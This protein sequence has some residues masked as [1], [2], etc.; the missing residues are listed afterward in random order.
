MLLKLQI[1]LPVAKTCT[2]LAVFHDHGGQALNYTSLSLLHC[3]DTYT[4]FSE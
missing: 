1:G 2:L 3:P 4:P